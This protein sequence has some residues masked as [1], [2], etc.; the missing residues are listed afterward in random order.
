MLRKSLCLGLALLFAPLACTASISSQG[1]GGSIDGGSSSGAMASSSGASSTPSGAGSASGSS[2]GFAGASG[3]TSPSADDGGGQLGPGNIV[4]TIRDFKFYSAADGTTVPDF[5]NPPSAPGPWDDPN[6]VTDTLGADGKP[7]YARTTGSTL[8]THGA[9]DF[10]KWYNDVA[11]TN[12][13]I[14]YTLPVL[15]LTS[16]A[17]GYDS[18]IQGLPYNGLG[19]RSDDGFFPIDGQGFGNQGA[20]HNYSFTVEIHAVFTYK[21]GETFQFSGDD[22]VFVFIDRKRV[23]NLG[24][25]HGPENATVNVDTL[26]LTV[27]KEY[28]LDFFSAER[29]QTGSNLKF[30]T[31]LALRPSV[32]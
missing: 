32:N 22:D 21:G 27:G 12:I 23:I 11:G 28:P 4:A 9:A 16:G 17:I 24:G 8:T 7:V 18:S 5:E 25:V 26:G 20:P 1:F 14:P 3:S 6:I 13:N 19:G 29:H 15:P 30:E 10:D 31:T 2:S